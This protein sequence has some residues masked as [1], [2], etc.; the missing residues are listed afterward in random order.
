M[1]RRNWDKYQILPLLSFLSHL[2]KYNIH[3]FL[4]SLWMVFGSLNFYSLNINSFVFFTKYS[5]WWLSVIVLRSIIILKIYFVNKYNSL[6]HPPPFAL[7]DHPFALPCLLVNSLTSPVSAS[8]LSPH[9]PSP[10]FSLVP[11]SYI[12]LF[13]FFLIFYAQNYL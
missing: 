12:S 11:P 8:L 6:P 4:E 13:L 1:R 9:P 5:T 10:T 7:S 3:K 2:K